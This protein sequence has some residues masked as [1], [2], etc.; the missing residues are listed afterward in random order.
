ME[1]SNRELWD[2]LLELVVVIL[3]LMEV[4]NRTK[5]L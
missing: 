5:L 3:I 2:I 1:V 4:S